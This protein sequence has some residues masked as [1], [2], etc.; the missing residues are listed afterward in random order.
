MRSKLGSL[1]ARVRS[2]K[3]WDVIWFQA[4]TSTIDY[5]P[6]QSLVPIEQSG[7]PDND[8]FEIIGFRRTRGGDWL[9]LSIEPDL[10]HR[11]SWV[12]V[13]RLH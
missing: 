13:R 5:A 7:D 4:E 11:Y 8:G 2:A 12:T 3:V 6:G 10:D 1:D 9:V